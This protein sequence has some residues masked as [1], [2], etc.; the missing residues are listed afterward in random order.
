MS[1]FNRISNIF[2]GNVLSVLETMENPEKG[3]LVIIEDMRKE[4]GE[5][6]ELILNAVTEEK[7]LKRQLEK[8]DEECKLWQ[9]RAQLAVENGKDDMAREAL[10]NKR[11][12][13]EKREGIHKSWEKIHADTERL[14]SQF[15][16][17][18]SKLQ[19]TIAKK[20]I[21]IAKAK[22]AKARI[23]A[24]KIS[25]STTPDRQ[26]QENFS[27]VEEKIMQMEAKADAEDEMNALNS[28]KN[29]EDA[30]NML[31][32]SGSNDIDAE[33]AALKSKLNE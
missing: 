25:M 19:E 30:W 5:M 28:D 8:L 29:K 26:L 18:E 14:K 10:Q 4:V 21:L 3:I 17:M 6:R 15:S 11:N 13:A 7:L 23:N 27:R 16:E 24:K 2:R 33:L 32:V 20:E 31:E 9:N 12:A 1:I 22:V